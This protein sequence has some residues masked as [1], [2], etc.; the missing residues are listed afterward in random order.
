VLASLCCD[1]IT[2]TSCGI[3]KSL[4]MTTDYYT[5]IIGASLFFIEDYIFYKTLGST[6]HFI[7]C[8]LITFHVLDANLWPGAPW[9]LD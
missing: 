8:I 5:S 3:N 7:N 4:G 2:T 9:M 1:M 6:F